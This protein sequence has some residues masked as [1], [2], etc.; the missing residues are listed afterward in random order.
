MINPSQLFAGEF[1]GSWRVNK[2]RCSYLI[3]PNEQKMLF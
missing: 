3:H 1:N 2:E